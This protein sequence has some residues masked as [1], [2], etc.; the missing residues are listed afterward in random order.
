MVQHVRIAVASRPGFPNEAQVKIRISTVAQIAGLLVIG[1]LAYDGIAHGSQIMLSLKERFSKAVRFTEQPKPPAP[2]PAL[3]P[4]STQI[5]LCRKHGPGFHACMY[6]AGYAVNTAWTSAHDR[7]T[8]GAA[9][10][11]RSGE[12]LKDAYRAEASPVYG[13]PYWVPRR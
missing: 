1:V 8:G 3:V 10:I 11:A 4:L 5:P 2:P 12:I 6:G 9:D 7:D 13:V